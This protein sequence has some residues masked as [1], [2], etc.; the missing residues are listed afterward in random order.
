MGLE[1]VPEAGEKIF[2][3]VEG[4]GYHAQH[5]VYEAGISVK[6]DG[7]MFIHFD[8]NPH[9][10]P[11]SLEEQLAVSVLRKD[12]VAALAL[13]DDVKD[14]FVEPE[15]FVSRERLKE[16]IV[17][18]KGEIER[19]DFVEKS[20]RGA[21]R[22][23]RKERD[24]LERELAILRESGRCVNCKASPCVCSRRWPGVVPKVTLATDKR[25]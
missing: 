24:D 3:V 7:R 6:N 15:G 21:L 13:A 20:L 22:D 18:L 25:E 2:L 12:A 17:E 19:G 14:R 10:T 9:G 4:R 11:L 23:V 16:I 1:W 5:L 8:L